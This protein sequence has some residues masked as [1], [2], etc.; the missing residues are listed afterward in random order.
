MDIKHINENLRQLEGKAYHCLK[1]VSQYAYDQDIDKEDYSKEYLFYELFFAISNY[2]RAITTLDLEKTLEKRFKTINQLAL[3]SLQQEGDNYF[4][5]LDK[6][7]QQY[8]SDVRYRKQVKIFKNRIDFDSLDD[9]NDDTKILMENDL[10]ALFKIRDEINLLNQNTGLFVQFFGSSEDLNHYKIF[11]EK[12][13]TIHKENRW[14]WGVFHEIIENYR[15]ALFV[16]VETA[17]WYELVSFS[18]KNLAVVMSANISSQEDK[19]TVTEMIKKTFVGEFEKI[20]SSI[21]E[22]VDWI[23]DHQKGAFDHLV[24]LS[25]SPTPAYQSWS[26][27]EPKPNP[28]DHG[29]PAGLFSS[30]PD[31]KEDVIRDLI[32]LV[33]LD[34]K[35]DDEQRKH[36]LA[37]AFLIIGESEKAHKLLNENE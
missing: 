19:K 16:P 7:G 35:L 6:F 21:N 1:T 15:T 33:Q 3:E 31:I 30:I 28:S 23:S 22:T 20:K 8:F 26:E 29:I 4:S 5:R 25:K 37:T 27:E 11:E 9:L 32:S 34:E 10:Y 13:V 17:W 2:E 18:P 36:I 24:S 12:I 14:I